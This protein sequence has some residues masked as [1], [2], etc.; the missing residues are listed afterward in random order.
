MPEITP[1]QVVEKIMRDRKIVYFKGEFYEYDRG[2]YR[3]RTLEWCKKLAVNILKSQSSRLAL[4]DVIE[5][6]SIQSARETSEEENEK[7]ILN[8]K[9]GLFCLDTYTPKPHT[10]DYF[11]VVQVPI[12]YVP[13]AECKRW[14]RFLGE[15]FPR[16][17]DV[18]PLIQEWFGYCLVPDCRQQKAMVLVG[19]GANGKSVFC[20]VLSDLVGR[21]NVSAV[22]LSQLGQTFTVALIQGKL[23]NVTT[24]VE[25][26]RSLEEGIFKALIAGDPV[27][28]E[29]KYEPPFFF[30]PYARFLIATNN[31]PSVNDTS[32]GLFRRLI[33]VRFE[34]QISEEKQDRD[35]PAKLRGELSG[36]LNWALEGLKRLEARGRF[37]IP[38]S[39]AEEIEEYRQESNHVRLWRE[40]CT[41]SSCTDWTTAEALWQSYRKWCLEKEVSPFSNI[42]FGKEL[43]RLLRTKS[44]L[45][46]DAR[47]RKRGY[48]GILL[49]DAVS[50]SD[51][52]NEQDEQ[53]S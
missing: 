14:I 2:V 8:L 50:E 15:C 25:M 13:E 10:P 33:I 29:R 43:G 48:K 1:M 46:G 3:K 6:L 17:S 41:K 11:S 49:N 51:R 9:N 37:D 53:V 39:V 38:A 47:N 4:G 42:K 45:V 28:A 31:L 32:D 23:L 16:Q 36:I 35:L 18:T 20:G 26:K 5:L 27:K 12:E 30:K 24:E 52:Q 19:E 22:S 21:E 7:R 44:V 34:E 40:E